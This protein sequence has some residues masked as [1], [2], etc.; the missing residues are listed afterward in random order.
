MRDAL[1][2]LPPTSLVKVVTLAVELATRDNGHA[3][4][5]VDDL[6]DS[7]EEKAKAFLGQESGNIT[8][9]ICQVKN[10]A[11]AKA[12]IPIGW[13]T[14]CRRSSATGIRLPN[15]IQMNARESRPRS[16]DEQPSRQ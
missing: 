7:Y 2:G 11:D 16:R 15:Q 14:S 10:A 12:G 5:L 6:V 4:I 13:S 8:A 9:L 1:D 3:P